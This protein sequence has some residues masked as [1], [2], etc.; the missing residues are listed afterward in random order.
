M[1]EPENSD[2]PKEH[3]TTLAE[4]L[5]T[6]YPPMRWIVPKLLG[7]GLAVLAG[8]PFI[9]KS[10]LALSWAAAATTGGFILGSQELKANPAKVFY[11]S[12]DDT[13][14]SLGKRVQHLEEQGISFNR[15]QL[16][17]TTKWTDGIE[18]LREY[19][20]NNRDIQFVII[21]RLEM[22]TQIKDFNNDAEV[23]PKAR[24][25]RHIANDFN[26]TILAVH[27]T[28]KEEDAVIE[29]W[30]DAMGSMALAEEADTLFL[31][32]RP[33]RDAKGILTATGHYIPDYKANLEFNNC[34]WLLKPKKK[35][36]A[37]Q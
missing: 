25:L 1:A 34:Q 14:D 5:N 12:L 28:W 23:A 7:E 16:L 3:I 9:G 29:D 20:S 27:Q 24:A 18:G 4:I 2:R 13:I 36:T 22:F 15:S 11:I 32:E 31:L 37:A 35:R 8:F 21:D 17:V 6:T 26:M 10:W 30:S 19:L 33:N